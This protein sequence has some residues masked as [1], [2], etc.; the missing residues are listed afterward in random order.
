M[1]FYVVEESRFANGPAPE[2]NYKWIDQDGPTEEH[3]RFTQS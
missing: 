1:S 2:S 3:R